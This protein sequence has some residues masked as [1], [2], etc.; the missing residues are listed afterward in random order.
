MKRI[1]A[2]I[3]ILILLCCKNKESNVSHFSL[4]GHVSNLK[5][6]T[7]LFLR[8]L[9]NSGAID[10]AIVKNE[11]FIFK[12]QL[13]EKV[14]FTMLHTQDKSQFTEIWLEDKPMTFD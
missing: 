8:D 6:G 11:T 3:L 2:L 1:V 14:L 12:T 10:S 7:K 9:V 5:N 4:E 13:P